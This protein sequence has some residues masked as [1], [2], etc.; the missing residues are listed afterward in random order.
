[1]VLSQNNP[2]GSQQ[3]VRGQPPYQVVI[4]NASEVALDYDGKPVDLVP[5]TSAGNIARLTLQ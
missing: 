4:G 2:A 1:V 5:V 3:I